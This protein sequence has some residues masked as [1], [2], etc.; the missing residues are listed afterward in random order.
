MAEAVPVT[1]LSAFSSP[2]AKPTKWSQARG[3]LTGA[4]VYWHSTVR[5]DGRPHVTPLLGIWLE[6]A[7][8]FCTGPTSGRRRTS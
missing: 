7:L 6:G 4:E 8:Y 3:E 5:P 2:N 1:E